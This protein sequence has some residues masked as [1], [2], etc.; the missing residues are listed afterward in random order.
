MAAAQKV[1]HDD[2]SG[3]GTARALAGRIGRPDVAQLLG[4]T[5]AEEENADNLL[6]Q[7]ARELIGHARTGT[8]DAREAAPTRGEE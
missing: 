6:T 4:K 7:I 5:L 3:Y 2:I 1:E 8:L